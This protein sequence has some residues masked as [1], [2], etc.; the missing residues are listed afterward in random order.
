HPQFDGTEGILARV[1]LAGG[2]PREVA[3]DIGGADWSPDGKELALV[4]SGDSGRLEFP[5]GA[6]ILESA[7][8]SHPRV[9]PRGDAVAVF[10]GQSF[11]TCAVVLVD[12][13]GVKR[14]LTGYDNRGCS[15][16]AWSRD[17]GEVWFTAADASGNYSIRA[18]DL[19]GHQRIVH[20][21]PGALSL[22]DISR[23]GG[24]VLLT[25]RTLRF[26]VQAHVPGGEGERDL[27]WLN[28]S[29]VK[30]LSADGTTLILGE[31]QGAAG[32]N[33]IFMRKTDGSP[34][35]RLGDGDGGRLSPDGKW[36]VTLSGDPPHIVLLP[37]G[38]GQP[39][40]LPTG[41]ARIAAVEWFHDGLRVLAHGHTDGP[42]PACVTWTQD[43]DGSAVVP[44]LEGYGGRM[45]S[46]DGRL[47]LAN[48]NEGGPLALC[49]VAGGSCG[50]VPGLDPDGD[51]PLRWSPDGRSL[52]V[53]RRKPLQLTLARID[54]ATGRVEIL[55]VVSPS[56]PDGV[57]GFGGRTG[58]TP[59]GRY[60]AYSYGRSLG[61]L[62]L[63]RGLR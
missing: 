50:N 20:A 13:R 25:R 32:A 54:V 3:E 15:G 47:V 18:V 37:T 22:R 33:P 58:I 11:F 46:P 17:G 35:V 26:R 38:A 45:P 24:D 52:L 29:Y 28:D 48:K 51:W 2:S 60:Y 21:N 40:V 43:I 9:S 55:K 10:E 57:F 61:D 34:A 8:M 1:S 44:I 39:R 19:E 36:V 31:F 49:P 59:D 30:D 12:R 56:E 14:T 16:L 6:P 4:R 62:Y 42:K 63:V 23:S 53:A 41:P 5:L 27:S 7:F